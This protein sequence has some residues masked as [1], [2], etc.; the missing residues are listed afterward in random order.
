M[1][2]NSIDFIQKYFQSLYSIDKNLI[3]KISNIFEFKNFEKNSF[4]AKQGFING[5]LAFI[6]KGVFRL[7]FITE[8]GKE[9]IKYFLNDYDVLLSNIQYNV[10]SR[11][12]IQAITDASIL[13]VPYNTFIY[14]CNKYPELESMRNYLI[15]KNLAKKEARE[16]N[17][18]S[19]DAKANYKIFKEEYKNIESQ[20]PQYYIASYLGITPTQ[21]SRLKKYL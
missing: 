7:F 12:S 21:L 13:Q 10:E 5:N 19:N 18:L 3:F 6:I 9:Y 20:I 17:L 1:D 14:N 16:I 4:F 11:V 8:E 2:R 15:N